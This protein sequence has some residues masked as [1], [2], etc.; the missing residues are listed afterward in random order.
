[1]VYQAGASEC[2]QLSRDEE[3]K[4]GSSEGVKAEVV[5]RR[6]LL[7]RAGH[8]GL[9]GERLLVGEKMEGA[10][11]RGKCATALCP[12]G[13]C[14]HY[15]QAIPTCDSTSYSTEGKRDHRLPLKRT[16]ALPFRGTPHGLEWHFPQCVPLGANRC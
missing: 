16:K 15:Q 11:L 9:E 7:L 6:T 12:G 4:V 5:G 10:G 13:G 8:R 1:M 3:S 14:R 2:Y